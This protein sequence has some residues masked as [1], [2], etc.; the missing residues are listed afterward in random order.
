MRKNLFNVNVDEAKKTCVVW[1]N[2]QKRTA[3]AVAQK[4]DKFDAQLGIVIALHKLIFGKKLTYELMDWEDDVKL[5]LN[6][7]ILID[8]F[9]HKINLNAMPTNK[10]CIPLEVT[11][12]DTYLRINYFSYYYDFSNL[13]EGYDKIKNLLWANIINYYRINNCTHVISDLQA[14]DRKYALTDINR[15]KGITR[16]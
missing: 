5:P 10:M 4:G 8:F 3:K 14:L 13:A 12:N 9:A 16:K 2:G 15:N 6:A 11:Y 1:T 7:D